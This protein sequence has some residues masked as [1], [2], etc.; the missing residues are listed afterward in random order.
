[1]QDS[2]WYHPTS[3]VPRRRQRLALIVEYHTWLRLT[4]ASLFE[5]LGF[6][7]ITATNGF[8]GLRRAIDLRPNIVLLGNGLP[9]LA[10]AHVAAELR[11]LGRPCGMQ[12]ILTSNLLTFDARRLP[13]KSAPVRPSR[14]WSEREP[15]RTLSHWTVGRSSDARPRGVWV[16][17]VGD[18]AVGGMEQQRRMSITRECG[19]RNGVCNHRGVNRVTAR[20]LQHP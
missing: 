17:G 10:T 15:R 20:R 1:M 14:R 9:E 4:L 19:L 2:H 16:E 5:E 13:E 11:R 12:V 8:A 7:V 18:A 3:S 6:A